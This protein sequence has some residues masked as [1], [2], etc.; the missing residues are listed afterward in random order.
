MQPVRC[1]QPLLCSRLSAN[2]ARLRIVILGP[3][4]SP[5]SATQTGS[6]TGAELIRRDEFLPSF[7]VLLHSSECQSR[8][9]PGQQPFHRH[10]KSGPAALLSRRLRVPFHT[11]RFPDTN[12]PIRCEPTNCARITLR[13]SA[14]GLRSSARVPRAGADY[15]EARIPTCSI[16]RSLPHGEFPR[17][18]GRT[19][20][21]DG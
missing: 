19:R 2:R 20:R 18:I 10:I 15:P 13:I 6:G 14:A 12:W 1:P 9:H 7:F 3:A 17:V 11:V 21:A 4:L 16:L 5:S 8:T